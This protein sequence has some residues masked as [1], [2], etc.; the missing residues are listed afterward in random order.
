MCRSVQLS[1]AGMSL[2]KS[3][4]GS[5][6]GLCYPDPLLRDITVCARTNRCLV[7]RLLI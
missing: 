6:L 2:K 4:L 1:E 5:H 7:R 3:F